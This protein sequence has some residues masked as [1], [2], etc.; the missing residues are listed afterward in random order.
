ME[1]EKTYVIMRSFYIG[2]K[3]FREIVTSRRDKEEAQAL[4][5][6]MKQEAKQS[7]R[8]DD[9]WFW[10]TDCWYTHSNVSS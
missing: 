3:E 7:G 2:G 1:L 8:S 10:E 4:C 9:Y 5:D 6:Q